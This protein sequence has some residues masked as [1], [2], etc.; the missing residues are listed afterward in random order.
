[1]WIQFA[2]KC[3]EKQIYFANVLK[4]HGKTFF[5]FKLMV[6]HTYWDILKDIKLAL[7]RDMLCK[8]TLNFIISKETMN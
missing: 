7:L 3:I 2:L 8:V 4:N 5:E 6:V 1:M